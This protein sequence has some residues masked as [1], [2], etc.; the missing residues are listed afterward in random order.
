MIILKNIPYQQFLLAKNPET[1]VFSILA[2]F[3]GEDPETISLKIAERLKKLTKTDAAREKYYAQLRVLSNIRK[4]QPTIDKIIA[5]IFKLI[6]ISQDPLYVERKQEGKQEGKREGV[7]EGK[8]VSVQSLISNSDFDNA[9]IALL[10][11]VPQ[12]F[13]ASIRAQMEKDKKEK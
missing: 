10:L 3:E 13:V 6:D 7:L 1:V 5:N 4:L 12:D 2:N 11:A 8:R 9:Y